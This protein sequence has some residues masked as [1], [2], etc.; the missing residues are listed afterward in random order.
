MISGTK[1]SK[2]RVTIA[3][4]C[5]ASGDH[6]LP[7]LFIHKSKTPRVLRGIDKDGLPVWYYWN[8]TAW[9]QASVWYD[10]LK[11]V[12]EMMRR[13]NRNILLLA[14]NAPTHIINENLPLTNINLH[15]LP[16]NTTSHLQPLDAGI[17]NSF[18]VR[19]KRIECFINL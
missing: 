15:F 2:N 4:T 16:P 5:N 12:N 6:K 14:D 8:R 3:L 9:M 11:K 10:Y 13:Q 17:I 7:P 19:K 1:K 18:K